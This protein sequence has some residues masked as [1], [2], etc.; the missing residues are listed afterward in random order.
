MMPAGA[1]RVIGEPKVYLSSDNGRRSFC[2]NCGTGL[3]FSNAVLDQ[4][5]FVQVRSAALDDPNAVS[6]EFQVQTAERIVWMET[7]HS[8]PGFKRFPE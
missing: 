6:P 5:G 7:A 4:M 1:L 8:L 3:F 2:A